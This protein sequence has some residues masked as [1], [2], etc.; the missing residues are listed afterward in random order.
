VATGDPNE[1]ATWIDRFDAE[2]A[3]VENTG[4]LAGATSNLHNVAAGSEAADFT[5]CV[6][7]LFRINRA[8]TI[9][10]LSDPIKNQSQFV[11]HLRGA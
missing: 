4:E 3:L 2:L 9:V 11:A 10:V 7:K 8:N 6:D 5:G 1:F